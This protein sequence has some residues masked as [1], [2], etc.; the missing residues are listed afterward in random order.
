MGKERNDGKTE[1]ELDQESIER[2][3]QA[4]KD[5]LAWELETEE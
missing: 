1:E 3:T 5:L 2:A 4:A